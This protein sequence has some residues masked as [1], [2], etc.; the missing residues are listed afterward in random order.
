M[1]QF[2]LRFKDIN[3]L[4]TWDDRLLVKKIYRTIFEEWKAESLP[5]GQLQRRVQQLMDKHFFSGLEVSSPTI[6]TLIF[7]SETTF[8]ICGPGLTWH[9]IQ[10][11]I[12]PQLE[13]SKSQID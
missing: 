7:L 12:L 8:R 5:K 9:S 6:P 11:R 13:K 4:K 2:F 10:G 3:Q 1:D